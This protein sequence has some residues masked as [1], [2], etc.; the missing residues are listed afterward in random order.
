V[1]EQAAGAAAAHATSWTTKFRSDR[2]V[3][4]SERGLTA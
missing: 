3:A 1:P 4:I 2:R